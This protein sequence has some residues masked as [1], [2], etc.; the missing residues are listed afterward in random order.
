MKCTESVPY[1]ILRLDMG[2]IIL[3]PE[4]FRTGEHRRAASCHVYFVEGAGL[5]KIGHANFPVERF[6]CMLTGCPVPLSL[7]ASNRGGPA[8][9]NKLHKQ[10]AHTRAHGEWFNR[11]PE[12]DDVIAAA[13]KQYGPELQNCLP[14][15]RKADKR[16][17]NRTPY[18]PI[19]WRKE[20]S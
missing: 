19:R 9:E 15:Y 16:P 2:L 5:I 18:L 8:L 6:L 11:T 3:P 12:L 20:A 7:L 13:E 4:G 10:F 1:H 17:R 14:A